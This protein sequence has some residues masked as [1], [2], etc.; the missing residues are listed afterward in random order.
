MVL[1]DPRA[2]LCA[3]RRP[4]G[5]SVLDFWRWAG[6]DLLANTQRGVL[7]EYLVGLSLGCLSGSRTEWEP[8]D[9]SF[10]GIR[11]EVKSSAYLQS[12]TRPKLS[13]V[14]FDVAKTR[15]WD[16][17]TGKYVGSPER[18]AHVYVFSLLAHSDR[19]SVDPL[20]VEQWTFYVAPTSLIDRR[21]GD[22]KT[23]GLS[24]VRRLAGN[25]LRWED[26]RSAVTEAG[27]LS[28]I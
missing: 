15:R 4:L 11:V 3:A 16:P 6:S 12:W 22:A 25:P 24:T 1:L 8:W 26:L 20:D 10:E 14:S 9:L 28:S 18:R 13:R 5:P 23:A 17:D 2:P 27:A 7:A 21:L 19:A